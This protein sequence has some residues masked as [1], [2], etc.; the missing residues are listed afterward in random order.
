MKINFS[1]LTAS[2]QQNKVFSLDDSGNLKKSSSVNPYAG[3]FIALS[4][5][6]LDQF[7]DVLTRLNERQSL[8]LG[9]IKDLPAGESIGLCTK[10]KEDATHISKTL[11]FISYTDAAGLMLID[12]DGSGHYTDFLNLFPEIKAA[13]IKPSSSSFIYDAYGNEV[14]GAKGWHLYIPVA[15]QSEIPAIAELL[16]QRQWLS[17][18]GHYLLSAG[19]N[20]AMLERGLF[21]KAVFSPERLIF[22]AKPTLHSGLVQNAPAPIVIGTIEQNL[23]LSD[24]V[25]YSA[26]DLLKIESLKAAAREAIRPAQK[27]EIKQAKR[28]YIAKSGLPAKVA[29]TNYKQISEGKLTHDFE[30]RTQKYGAV[31]IA[32]LLANPT[33]F[34]NCTLA[35]PY[36]PDYDGGSKTKA[37]FYWNNGVNPIINSQAHGGIVYRLNAPTLSL[38][39]PHYPHKKYL[40]A[41]E[42]SK[43]IQSLTDN[44]LKKL[45]AN[46]AI[47]A[48]AGSGKTRAVINSLSKIKVKGQVH[49]FVPTHDLANEW[50]TNLQKTAPHLK[51]LHLYGRGGAGSDD[52]LCHRYDQ[53]QKVADKK[54]PI[55][56]TM[57]SQNEDICPFFTKCQYIKQF[58]QG[59]DIVILPHSYLK[60][61]HSS[62]ELKPAAV[63]IDERFFNELISSR[64]Y[65]IN[66]ISEYEALKDFRFV[67]MA[68]I[69]KVK[70]EKK[71]LFTA[72]K[73]VTQLDAI[74]LIAF[75]N[76]IMESLGKIHNSR[77][78]H[79]LKPTSG[80]LFFENCLSKIKT[81]EKE[82]SIISALLKELEQFPEREES[83]NFRISNEV[84]IINSLHTDNRFNY[85]LDNNIPILMIDADCNKVIINELLNSRKKESELEKLPFIFNE[86]S[87]KRQAKVIQYTNSQFAKNRF[88]P[89][90][91]KTAPDLKMIDIAAR[92]I[93]KISGGKNTLVVTYKDLELILKA[94]LPE[95]IA[96]LHF[97]AIRGIDAYKHFDKVIILGRNQ[98]PPSDMENLAAALFSNDATQIQFNNSYSKES[99]RYRHENSA[100]YADVYT[101]ADNRVQVILEQ[102]RE[103]ELLQAIDRLRFIHSTDAEREIHIL[104]DCVLDI[105]VDVIG[106]STKLLPKGRQAL[107]EIMALNGGILPL[108]PTLLF[109][110]YPDKFIN[111]QQ[112]KDDL[113]QSL[114]DNLELPLKSGIS[115]IYNFLLHKSH[116][117]TYRLSSQKRGNNL[118]AVF[119]ENLNPMDVINR[120][121][122]LHGEPIQVISFN[123]NPKEP[124][125]IAEP[126]A[127][128]SPAVFLDF[129]PVVIP[130]PVVTTEAA[131][132]FCVVKFKLKDGTGG[133]VLSHDSY[134]QTWQNLVDRYG[135][136][137]AA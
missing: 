124:Q 26:D 5:D 17:G 82:I 57:C 25:T 10:G 40:S 62:M 27:V 59:D 61:T 85:Y 3:K 110:R 11:D 56:A 60:L 120:L 67:L 104:T 2:T 43:K 123:E 114:K 98:P 71:G 72:L 38:P 36:D 54:I 76:E 9:T 119:N 96:V 113:R 106:D 95:N 130:E 108:S 23:K 91:D 7:A 121:Q 102:F 46:V 55:F 69:A 122:A 52:R 41:E 99:R 39:K 97:G 47:K 19:V 77:S 103:C 48:S 115:P 35:D 132:S 134:E 70:E 33:K 50:Q 80:E 1:A 136:R 34:N 20:P 37:R 58:N 94:S 24:F 53:V 135:E 111:I 75:F 16:W 78:T 14:I 100:V 87:V 74:E 129:A 15:K 116:S 89:K 8:I 6:G 88:F 92:T 63:V 86:I 68:A 18:R 42:S 117:M 31:K 73:E 22:E 118:T 45:G 66:A 90:G 79:G 131:N 128:P 133:Q 12:I 137:L 29:L 32:D 21:D 125:H 105:D 83:S 84:Y 64:T 49:V 112:V 101:H 127:I 126:V 107:A 51:V 30:V 44:F 65:K 13:V 4:V 93:E 109:N 28:A 81:I